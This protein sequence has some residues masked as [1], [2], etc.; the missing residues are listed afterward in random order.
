MARAGP[1]NPARRSHKVLGLLIS[2]ASQ[3]RP[4]VGVLT[5]RRLDPVS[6]RAAGTQARHQ[7][8]GRR[9]EQNED[10]KRAD[11]RPDFL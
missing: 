3:L 6:R 5:E 1:A 2:A 4:G 11:H 8:R 7:P 10:D 9:R